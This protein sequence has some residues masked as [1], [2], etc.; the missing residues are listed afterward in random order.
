VFD[1]GSGGGPALYAGGVFT[2]AGGMP[3]NNIAKWQ[4]CP[5]P[6]CGL[7]DANCDGAVNVD[8]LVAVILGWGACTDCPPANCP[9]DVNDDC[10]VNVDDLII[11]ILNWGP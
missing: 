7:G 6:P 8:D 11:V 1:D 4:G 9:A 10:A 3:A 5:P 2:T